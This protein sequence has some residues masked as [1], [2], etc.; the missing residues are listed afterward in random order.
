MLFADSNLLG[1]YAVC[2]F[3]SFRF[4]YDPD[5]EAYNK[6]PYLDLRC[7]LSVH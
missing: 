7:L 2:R 1:F 3:K 5:E 4:F 6:Q